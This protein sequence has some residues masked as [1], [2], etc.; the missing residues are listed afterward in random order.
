M[1]LLAYTDYIYRR[2]GSA[3]YAE[4]AF[5]LFLERVGR[6]VG[7][8]TVLGRLDPRAGAAPYPLA[9]DVTF[10]EL[11]Y[12]PALLSRSAARAQPRAL[13][14]AWRAL[15]DVDAVWALGPHPFALC[16]AV[17][18]RARGRH[19]VLGVRQNTPAYVRGRHPDRR[20]VHIA[21]D[22]LDGGFRAFARTCPVVVVGPELARRYADSRRCL[23]IAVSL[24]SNEDMADVREFRARDYSGE[25]RL[26]SVGRLEAEKN[27]LLL[28]DVLAELRSADPRWRLIVCGEGP[29]QE[30]LRARL[31]SLGLA[32]HAELLGYVPLRPELLGVYRDSHAFVHVSLTEG[33]PQ[34]L[35]EAF[36]T[37][38]PVVATAV[39]GVPEAAAG[40]ALLVPP[41]DATAIAG[42]L[43]R[44]AADPALRE[45]LTSA[46]AARAAERTLEAEARRVARFIEQTSPG[47]RPRG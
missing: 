32:A 23:D 42:A 30:A 27:P 1:R 44:I 22:A 13:A 16:L 38:V 34:V 12:Y 37:R 7:G 46:G 28:A 11:P 21:A 47:R 5:S 20:L 10:V 3:V 9:D 39:G 45:R 43:A 17:M 6:E 41:R 26:L 36:A 31:E 33:V 2:K 8:M 40:A 18:A 15:G 4:R 35:S 24:V 25:L 14:R 19:T 29:L